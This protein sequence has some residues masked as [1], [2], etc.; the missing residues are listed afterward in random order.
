[1]PPDAIHTYLANLERQLAA[2]LGTE[3][4]HR[5]ALQRLLESL[6]FGLSATNESKRIACGVIC[7]YATGLL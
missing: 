1:M 2:G 7:E 5:P 6:R 4:S 3:H